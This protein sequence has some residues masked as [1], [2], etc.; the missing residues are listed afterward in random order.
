MSAATAKP[1]PFS[2]GD[3]LRITMM[4]KIEVINPA[5]AGVA[6]PNKNIITQIS[7][8]PACLLL[9]N[10]DSII[11]IHNVAIGVMAKRRLDI[12]SRDLFLS[13]MFFSQRLDEARVYESLPSI[14]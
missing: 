10:T 6:H 3:F 4:L 2:I 9:I 13:F 1:I 5:T 14:C 8:Q 11:R 7:T 12:E